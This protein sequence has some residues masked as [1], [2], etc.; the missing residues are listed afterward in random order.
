MRPLASRRR[1][2]TVPHWRCTRHSGSLGPALLVVLRSST[3]TTLT[4]T[5]PYRYYPRAR[6]RGRARASPR[7]RGQIPQDRPTGRGYAAIATTAPKLRAAGAPGTRFWTWTLICGSPLWLIN[8]TVTCTVRTSSR[9]VCLR[10][11]LDA[12]VFREL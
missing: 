3:G 6:A 11:T 2:G 5:L 8:R 1:R 4:L 12:L 9:S 10:A 7:G